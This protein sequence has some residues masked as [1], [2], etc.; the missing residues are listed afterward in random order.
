[1]KNIKSYIEFINEKNVRKGQW[2]KPMIS[3]RGEELVDLVQTAYKKT[4]DGSYINSVGDLKNS[5]WI[6][7][8]FNDDPELDITIFYRHP[9]NNETWK[10]KKIQGIGHNGSD[11]AKKR[12][13]EKLQDLLNQKGWWVEASEALEA[14]LYKKGI[15]Y[16]DD[17]IYARK[18]FPNSNLKFIGNKGQYTRNTGSK[19]I[20][21]TIFGI[22]IVQ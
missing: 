13:L 2:V 10:G 16:V 20:K 15:P 8:D 5:E 4:S 9:R 12:V 14:V 17:E 19:K 6:A 1:M 7:K 21:E 22:P 3:S 11:A 18:V